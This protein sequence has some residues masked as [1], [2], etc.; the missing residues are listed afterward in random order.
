MHHKNGNSVQK[1]SV[2]QTRLRR[3]P[4]HLIDYETNSGEEDDPTYSGFVPPPKFG[5][6][7]IYLNFFKQILISF[8][9]FNYYRPTRK[10]KAISCVNNLPLLIAFYFYR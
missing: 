10:L 1:S 5:T 6:V 9:M 3:I 8:P 2:R 7:N 4:S